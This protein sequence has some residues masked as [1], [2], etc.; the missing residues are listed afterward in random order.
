MIEK[1]E[2]KERILFFLD[3]HYSGGGTGMG[4]ESMS[5]SGKMNIIFSKLTGK[6]FVIL[7]DDARCFIGEHSYSELNRL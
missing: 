3:G 1:V 2:D 7:I 6:Y 4:R 5:N